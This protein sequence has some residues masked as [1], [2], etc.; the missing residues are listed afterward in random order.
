MTVLGLY[1]PEFTIHGVA[2]FDSSSRECGT[3]DDFEVLPN[4]FV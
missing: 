4:V 2:S 3:R 1:Y